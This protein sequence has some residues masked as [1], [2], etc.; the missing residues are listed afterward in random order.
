MRQ[1]RSRRDRR[2]RIVDA[3]QPCR[4]CGS[5]PYGAESRLGSRVRTFQ[6]AELVVALARAQTSLVERGGLIALF[7]R[8]RKYGVIEGPIK[9]GCSFR[10]T[11]AFFGCRSIG[12]CLA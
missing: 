11:F 8:G 7:A 4:A 6:S 2:T 3:V 1:R 10:W 5:R 12:L 9:C